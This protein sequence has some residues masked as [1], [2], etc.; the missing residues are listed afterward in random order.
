MKKLVQVSLVLLFLSGLVFVSVK[1]GQRVETNKILS[2]CLSDVNQ[3]GKTE[4][5]TI[6]ATDGKQLLETGEPY[7]N[8]LRI[9]G[10]ENPEKDALLYEFDLSHLKPLTVQTGDVNGDGKKEISIVVYKETQF[11]PVLAKRPFFYALTEGTL[12]K[13]WLGSRLSR[14][15]TDFVLA[16]LDGDKVEEI[17]SIEKTKDEKNVVA[18]YSWEGFGF[19]M[20]CESLSYDEKLYFI[21]DRHKECTEVIIQ[22]GEQDY[23]VELEKGSLVLKVR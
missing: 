12:E 13:I 11:H 23:R 3:D 22:C 15:F 10:Q 5:L 20:V 2:Y 18:L 16:D 8:L 7:G 21:H 14:P 4:C 9:Y 19:D 1:N 17:V 6:E